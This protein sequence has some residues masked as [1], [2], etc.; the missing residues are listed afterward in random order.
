MRITLAACTFPAIELPGIARS[1]GR[2]Q[3]GRHICGL[4]TRIL[5][6]SSEPLPGS[7]CATLTS[8]SRSY[9]SPIKLTRNQCLPALRAWLLTSVSGPSRHGFRHRKRHAN[10][11]RKKA[12]PTTFQWSEV[13][14]TQAGPWFG[15]PTISKTAEAA[16]LFDGGRKIELKTEF[17]R[18][19]WTS[20][21]IRKG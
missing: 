3:S 15:A 16:R 11:S 13:T 17:C 6:V 9:C 2:E 20:V 7:A 4:R 21:L 8:L 10:G 12:E 14:S 5:M 18:N 19:S 1:F